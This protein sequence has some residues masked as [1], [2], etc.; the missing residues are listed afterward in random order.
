MQAGTIIDAVHKFRFYDD[1]LPV[2]SMV[3]YR[4]RIKD[5]GL[6]HSASSVNRVNAQWMILVCFQDNN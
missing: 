4:L 5:S 2:A 6:I 3:L 1:L